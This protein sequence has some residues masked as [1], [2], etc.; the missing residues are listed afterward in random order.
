MNPPLAGGLGGWEWGDQDT[1]EDGSPPLSPYQ[2]PGQPIRNDFV[3]SLNVRSLTAGTKTDAICDLLDMHKNCRILCLQEIWR[4]DFI[5]T[6][7]GFK[8]LY[9]K[10]RST[11]HA[12]GVG[13]Y[14]SDKFEYSII[15]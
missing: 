7:P 9:Y 6:L 13:I 3:L 1:C 15:D 11:N 14:I 2:L 12:G 5:P 8:K 4:L 10:S